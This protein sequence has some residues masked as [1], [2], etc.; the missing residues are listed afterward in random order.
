MAIPAYHDDDLEK[1][2]A[3]GAHFVLTKTK[4]GGA[5]SDKAA[6][7]SWK[8]YKPDLAEVKLHRATGLIGFRPNSLGLVVVDQDHDVESPAVVL[9][10]PLVVIPTS[11]PGGFHYYYRKPKG[12]IP[13]RMWADPKT[14]ALGGDIRCSNGYIMLW[15]AAKIASIL[16]DIA[17]A[18]SPEL[19]YLPLYNKNLD[20][21]RNAPEGARN[22]TLVS[23]AFS[24][25]MQGNDPT[26]LVDAAAVAGQTPEEISKTMESARKG[27]VTVILQEAA[28]PEKVLGARGTG[29]WALTPLGDACRLLEHAADQLLVSRSHEGV[30]TIYVDNGSGVW[31][32]SKDK[33]ERLILESALAWQHQV[34]ETAMT[35]RDF[36]GHNAGKAANWAVRAARPKGVTECLA[37]MDQ[38]VEALREY[39]MLPRGLT[40]CYEGQLN[41][42]K[43]SLG[44]PNGVI[45]LNTGSLLSPQEGR[46]RLVTR[47]VPDPF[48]PDAVHK[49]VD[50]LLRHLDPLKAG[51][52]LAA[53][54]FALRGRPSR[55][56]YLLAGERNG[57]KTTILNAAFGCLGNV[58]T[59][60]YGMALG[61]TAILKSRFR[62]K[63]SHDGALFGIQDARIVINEEPPSD[64][65]SEFDVDVLNDITG[66]G[67][68]NLRDVGEKAGA[69]RPAT[70]TLFA[71]VNYEQLEYLNLSRLSLADRTRILEYPELPKE[72]RDAT[73]VTAMLDEAEVRQASL[74]L[75]VRHAKANRD[76]PRDIKSVTD[77]V[78]ER[79]DESLGVVGVWLRDHL[80]VTRDEEDLVV[81][82]DLWAEAANHFGKDAD[83]TIEGVDRQ[84]AWRKAR[85]AVKNLPKAR[86][87]KKK[88]T[89]QGVKFEFEAI[90]DGEVPEFCTAKLHDGASC[91]QPIEG[92]R[93]KVADTHA[94]QDRNGG[95]PPA[96]T[97]GDV[98]Q[99][100]P[101][102]VDRHQLLFAVAVEGWIDR[103]ASR[104][105]KEEAPLIDLGVAPQVWRQGPEHLVQVLASDLDEIKTANSNRVVTQRINSLHILSRRHLQLVSMRDLL[106][107]VKAHPQRVPNDFEVEMF[108]GADKLVYYAAR[109]VT[110]FDKDHPG[111][112]PLEVPAIDWPAVLTVWRR[113]AAEEIAKGR[114][115]IASKASVPWLAL[116]LP[117][118]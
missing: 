101:G 92:G 24:E 15:D 106:A 41:T 29:Q 115:S 10:D 23:A 19:D 81:L 34:Q 85:L 109:A 89:W 54:G 35:D 83:G 61:S 74:A 64:N 53:F 63:N 32:P 44:A 30:H 17:S 36:H 28:T 113:W 107:A 75:L 71:A 117:R 4:I 42:D 47:T 37:K 70:G 3:A 79:R 25:E 8:S 80:R 68:M 78:D 86:T 13:N 87:V 77:A 114:K 73:R 46:K 104:I 88:R 43:G 39:E 57:G 69:S 105:E 103:L 62:Q 116:R 27:A 94:G 91:G 102:A 31:Q 98:Q 67:A 108:G 50:D 112:E 66:G 38:A 16:P 60:G 49:Y 110:T 82:D 33:L 111:H 84:E 40:L 56:W 90:E 1:L 48:L 100:L 76:V 55:R 7:Q 93:C 26:P 22:N 6:F 97:G 72:G 12:Y 95:P 21:V 9:G 11:K 51:Y 18:F 52:I 45:D 2:A 59:N 118:R 14:L 20:A 99:A 96:V 65:T 5:K 58:T